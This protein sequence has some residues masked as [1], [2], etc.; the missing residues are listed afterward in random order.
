MGL[1]QSEAVHGQTRHD[2]IRVIGLHESVGEWSPT[3]I[4]NMLTDV[5]KL[6]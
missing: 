4:V 1:K 6:D 5:L 3:V 2:Y